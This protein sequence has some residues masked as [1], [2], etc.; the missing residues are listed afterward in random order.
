MVSTLEVCLFP[1]QANADSLSI[2]RRSLSDGTTP[3]GSPIPERSPDD[4]RGTR[5]FNNWPYRYFGQHTAAPDVLDPHDSIY[6]RATTRLG[7][8]FQAGLPTWE[9]QQEYG[10]GTS[11]A[12]WGK[13]LEL[14]KEK[15]AAEQNKEEGGEDTI[16]EDGTTTNSKPRLSNGQTNG[17]NGTGAAASA[18]GSENGNEAARSEGEPSR[19]VS[20]S[21]APASAP[22]SR[23][24]TIEPPT[25]ITSALDSTARTD[26]PLKANGSGDAQASSIPEVE[27]LASISSVLRASTPASRENTPVKKGRGRPR[28]KEY[29]GAKNAREEAVATPD[30]PVRDDVSEAETEEEFNRGSEET[31]EVIWA[32]LASVLDSSSKCRN[33]WEKTASSF[34]KSHLDIEIVVS[35]LLTFHSLFV[36]FILVCS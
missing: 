31:I 18:T 23:A 35:L 10:I 4:I 29:W 2:F 25:Q 34:S 12:A 30:P 11:V 16:M 20:P 17:T 7:P 32:P 19:R 26:S 8:K 14:E 13:R 27:A 33:L 24:A 28:K 3:N 1:I 5:C 6:P 36:H 22:A 21:S 9:E 15:E